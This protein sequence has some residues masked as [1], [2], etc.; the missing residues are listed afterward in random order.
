MDQD[1]DKTRRENH[2]QQVMELLS[3]MGWAV[4]ILLCIAT[5]FGTPEPHL[6][7]YSLVGCLL[8]V[9]V[10]VRLSYVNDITIHISWTNGRAKSKR[11]K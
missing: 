4:A 11:A 3:W 7:Q 1:T 9:M 5:V 8:C 6:G 10:M 2:R